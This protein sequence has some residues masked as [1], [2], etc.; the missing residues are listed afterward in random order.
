ML[1]TIVRDGVLIER[2]LEV[3]PPAF[4]GSGTRLAA[5]P[6]ERL[7]FMPTAARGGYRRRGAGP[8]GER[9][10]S[11]GG[12]APLVGHREALFSGLGIWSGINSLS[13][14]RYGEPS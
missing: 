8:R 13:R 3:R 2:G 4:A 9:R 5:V 1:S 12:F 11:F 7:F 14:I 6:V 10:S